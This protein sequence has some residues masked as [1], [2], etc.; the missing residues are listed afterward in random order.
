MYK[1]RFPKRDN[2]HIIETFSYK[3]FSNSIPNQWIIR[4]LTKRDYGTDVLIEYVT[5]SGD[6]TGYS[7]CNRQHKSA[8]LGK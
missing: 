4:D 5:D 1:N 6:V 8:A 2:N 3:V 7:G